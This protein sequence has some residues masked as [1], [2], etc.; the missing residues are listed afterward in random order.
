MLGFAPQRGDGQHADTRILHFL[1]DQ[2]RQFALDLVGDTSRTRE[3]LRHYSARA[4]ST[5][6]NTSRMSPTWMS[7]KFFSDRPHSKLALTSLT[8]SLKRLSESSS[9][10]WITTLLRMRRTPAPRLTTPSVT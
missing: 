2:F 9:P 3:V 5:T 8:S 4:T 1:P 7:L 10:W 6:S